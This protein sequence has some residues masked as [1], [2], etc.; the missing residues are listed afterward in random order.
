MVGHGFLTKTKWPLPN[1]R[2]PSF[3]RRRLH[4][5]A[6]EIRISRHVWQDNE[7]STIASTVIIALERALLTP[8]PKKK[9]HEKKTFG[10]KKMCQFCIITLGFMGRKN[11]LHVSYPPTV[12]RL[13]SYYSNPTLSE[14]ELTLNCS[15][16]LQAAN[17][18]GSLRSLNPV[19]PVFLEQFFAEEFVMYQCVLFWYTKP[20]RK[21]NQ[22]HHVEAL[23]PLN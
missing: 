22:G 14:G 5:K 3:W 7:F 15:T 6:Q 19:V 4:V 21:C 16:L 8:P 13:K 9:H 20:S 18:I 1:L 2:I 23:H 12:W 10:V 17:G 11:T